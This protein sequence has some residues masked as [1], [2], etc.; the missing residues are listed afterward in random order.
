MAVK[1]SFSV[2]NGKLTFQ[3]CSYSHFRVRF[4]HVSLT[5]SPTH[6]LVILSFQYIIFIN[7]ILLF[8]TLTVIKWQ[9]CHML[10][11]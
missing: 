3:Q 2:R 9:L 6:T 7:V 10:S 5:Y 4:R 1:T 11:V 8:H